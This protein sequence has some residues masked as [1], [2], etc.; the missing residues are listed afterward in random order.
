[1]KSFLRPLAMLCLFQVIVGC[2]TVKLQSKW[3]E[4]GINI[5]GHIADWTQGA[6]YI[7]DAKV[8]LVLLNDEQYLYMLLS[9]RETQTIEQFLMAGF[10][11]YFDPRG[12][13]DKS[14]GIK[15]PVGKKPSEKQEP[16]R[17]NF[18]RR[19]ESTGRDIKMMLNRAGEFIDIVN[20]SDENTQNSISREYAAKIGIEVA[21]SETLDI[22]FYEIKVPLYRD[23]EHPYAIGVEPNDTSTESVF[24][25]VGFETGKIDKDAMGKPPE[26]MGGGSGGGPPGGGMGGGPPGD[27][28]GGGRGGGMGGGP[29]GGVGGRGD[30][31][32]PEP[33]ELWTSV[34]LALKEAGAQMQTNTQTK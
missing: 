1:M 28:M 12:G 2:N 16:Q 11:I 29:P 3:R 4:S 5:D 31:Q 22:F 8:R 9:T 32:M 10:T 25:G 6:Y 27:G 15:Y 24:I 21:L 19:S 34:E 20:S 13:K 33:L 17:M 26:G 30:M 7:E 14:F 18:D 23:K